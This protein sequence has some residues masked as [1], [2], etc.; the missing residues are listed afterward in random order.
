MEIVIDSSVAMGWFAPAQANELTR[1]ALIVIRDGAALVPAHFAHEVLRSL[2]RLHRRRSLGALTV[3]DAIDE[4][5]RLDIKQDERATLALLHEIQRLAVRTGLN[6]NDSA[7]LELALRTGLPLAS[8][9]MALNAAAKAIG[10]KLF[11]P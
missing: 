4:L 9:D 8:C 5:T 3:V 7:F 10:A 11:A 2:R 1:G 6:S